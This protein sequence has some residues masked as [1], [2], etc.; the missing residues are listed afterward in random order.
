MYT[1]CDM[2]HASFFV[3]II[4]TPNLWNV[5]ILLKVLHIVEY[6]HN[7]VYFRLYFT[8]IISA[9]IIVK[10][11]ISTLNVVIQKVSKKVIKNFYYFTRITL[12]YTSKLNA[13]IITYLL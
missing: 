2:C 9:C 4:V 3:V 12:L 11:N 6:V 5:Y 13:C 7:L 8:G 10:T 1:N